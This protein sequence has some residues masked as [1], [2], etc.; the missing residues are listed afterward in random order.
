MSAIP[1]EVLFSRHRLLAEIGPSGQRALM[2]STCSV[3]ASLGRVASDAAVEYLTRSGV[4]VAPSEASSR[5][6]E[7]PSEAC[8]AELEGA[9][10]AL[11]HVRRVVGV[12]AK[13]ALAEGLAR[14]PHA[15]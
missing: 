15:P 13:L 8:L 9:L 11:E 6:C 5:P 4:Q 1:P 12:S 3:P 10:F 2:E 7:D 14:K